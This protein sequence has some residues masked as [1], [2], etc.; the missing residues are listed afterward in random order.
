LFNG[1]RRSVRL[2]SSRQKVIFF[3]L[4]GARLVNNS[5]D[6]LGLMAVGLLAAMV[7]S[8][9]DGRGSATFLGITLAIE[10]DQTY[11]SIVVAI[12]LFFVSKSLVGV[13]LLRAIT[14]FLAKVESMVAIE[15]ATF[16]YSGGLSRLQK[17]SRGDISFA[18]SD[19]P[20]IAISG[21]LVSGSAILT[22]SA[23]FLAMF[24]VFLIVDSSTALIIG[25]YFISLVVIFQIGVNKRLRRSG[26]LIS[27]STIGLENTIQDMSITFREI[28]VFSKKDF[29]LDK[30]GVHRRE[31]ATTAGLL[32]FLKGLPRFFVETSLMVGVLAL[33]GFQFLWGNLSE[34]LVTTGVFLAGGFRMMTALL[35]V[36][37]A[38][39][40]MK[41]FGPQ[42]TLAQSLLLEARELSAQPDCTTT[43]LPGPL[44]IDQG[45][46]GFPLAVREVTFAHSDSRSPALTNVSIE[47]PPGKFVAI[48]GPSGAGKTTL[49]DLILGVNIPNSGQIRVANTDPVKLRQIRPGT[50][51]YV[52]QNPGL[53]IGTIAE[54]IAFGEPTESI[55]ELR[56]WKAL[57][58]AELMDFVDKLP[59]GIHTHLG[60]QADGLSGG[61][62]QRI[63]LA[64][65]LYS[66]PRLLVLDEATSALDAT[67]EASISQT[68]QKL[69]SSTTVIVIAHRLSTI[70]HADIV[71]VIENGSISAQGT[72]SEVRKRA[73][74]VEEYVRLMEIEN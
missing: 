17:F 50:I 11:V 41:S 60:K 46:A 52:P 26:Q 47:I 32:S 6:I 14:L 54:N 42:A 51:S 38:V 57:E 25:A 49:A 59:N 58:K 55:D 12:A 5:L 37:T 20:K 35:P 61:Q 4:L 1:F 71:Y 27:D 64:R 63:G 8:D 62:R 13:L 44:D 69:G 15:I 48:V 34:G 36:Q 56:V 24:A 74:I 43:E 2:L 45:N 30:F 72:F 22:E 67:I 18:V 31:Y 39:A 3:S 21:L 66:N 16:L 9:L 23:L 10:S 40:D 19:S 28:S 65:A 68:I 7:S 73:P 33:V 70:Q 53:L 29:F